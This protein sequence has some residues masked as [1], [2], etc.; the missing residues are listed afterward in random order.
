MQVSPTTAQ[1]TKDQFMQLLVTQLQNQDPLDPIKQYDFL[2]QLAQFS[3]L[4]GIEKLNDQVEQQAGLQA[5]LLQLQQLSQ[6]AQLVGS[7]ITYQ[8]TETGG[9]IEGV[10]ESV[11]TRNGRLQL[12][13]GDDAVGLDQ[14]VQ[15]LGPSD[16]DR[17]P[18]AAVMKLAG[19]L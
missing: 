5:E 8:T 1:D 7:R 17:W 11:S 4:E 18:A 10:V 15:I 12:N 19:L 6:A 2:S 3:T 13:V 9:P 14:V 16:D